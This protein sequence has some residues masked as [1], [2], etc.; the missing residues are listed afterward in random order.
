MPAGK[1]SY[2]STVLM[3]TIPASVAGVK[4]IIMT[5]PISNIEDHALAIVAADLCKVDTIM[6]MGGAIYS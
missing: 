3:N 5:A 6:R 2:P 4:K 1:A